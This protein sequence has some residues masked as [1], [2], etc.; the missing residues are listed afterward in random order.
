MSLIVKLS[1]MWLFPPSSKAMPA[2]IEGFTN[3][4]LMPFLHYESSAVA[5]DSVG[6]AA[7]ATSC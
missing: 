2:Q 5:T 3:G 7:P 6:G 1:G 4:L